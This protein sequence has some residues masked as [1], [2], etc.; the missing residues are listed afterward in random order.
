MAY[1][2]TVAN[3]ANFSGIGLHTGEAVALSIC[4]A[5]ENEGIRFEVLPAGA[6]KPFTIAARPEN[7]AGSA[8]A[9]SLGDGVH[10]LHTVEHLLAALA[11]L[12]VDNALIRM[13]ANEVPIM[14]GSAAPFV[15]GIVN[16]GVV[17]QGA[18]S[19]TIRITRSIR[20][21]DGDKWV[22]LRPAASAQTSICYEIDFAHPTVGRQQFRFVFT[23]ENFVRQLSPARTFGFVHE[24][25]ALR[26]AGLARGGSLD[27]AIVVGDEGVLNPGGLR[28]AD[29]FVRHKVLDLIGDFALAGLSVHADITAIRSGHALHTRAVQAILKATD[30]WELVDTAPEPVFAGSAL[31]AAI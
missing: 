14:D 19:R 23:R 28:F 2:R 26:Q 10:T 8:Y 24:V 12:G 27:N 18:P 21:E 7:L 3:E 16:A 31:S 20:V 17:E 25:E 5:G 9:T 11:G 4:P 13:N 30:S 6:D 22:E 1:Q 29:E 15:E